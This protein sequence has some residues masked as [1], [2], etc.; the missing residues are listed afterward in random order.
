MLQAVQRIKSQ[1]GQA[2][3]PTAKRNETLN[4]M[5]GQY[6]KGLARTLSP[7]AK[8]DY[9]DRRHFSKEDQRY[10]MLK[11][12]VINM[13]RRA[14]YG[15]MIQGYLLNKD[16]QFTQAFDRYHGSLIP[17]LLAFFDTLPPQK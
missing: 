1:R 3:S 15:K 8:S 7:L 9:V 16:P 5:T 13:I 17:M 11:S 6:E 10:F 2:T 14:D 4:A 12:K